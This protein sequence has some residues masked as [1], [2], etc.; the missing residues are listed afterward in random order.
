MRSATVGIKDYQHRASE[1][2]AIAS[3]VADADCRRS[4]LK[5]AADYER[6]AALLERQFNGGAPPAPPSNARRTLN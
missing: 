4:L 3:N 1:I 5:M 6:M 2:R